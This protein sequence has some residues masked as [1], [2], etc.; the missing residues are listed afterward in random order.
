MGSAYLYVPC[1]VPHNPAQVDRLYVSQPAGFYPLTPLAGDKV[2]CLCTQGSE[3]SV[4]LSTENK[5]DCLLRPRLA[6]YAGVYICS[7][8][9][10]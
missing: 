4:G 5:S 10:I 3:C 9:G 7:I 2:S 6:L 8:D 1:F